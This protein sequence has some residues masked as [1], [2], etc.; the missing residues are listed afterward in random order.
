[1]IVNFD[2]GPDA[3]TTAIPKFK[4]GRWKDRLKAKKAVEH[5]ARKRAIETAE[6]NI[7][8]TIPITA[9]KTTA[10]TVKPKHGDEKS[11]QKPAPQ[12][13]KAAEFV[14]SLWTGNPEALSATTGDKEEEGEANEPSN[15]PLADGSA[16]FVTLGLS[17]ILANHLARKLA[18]RAPTAIQRS[19]IPELISTDSD[20]FIQAETGSGKTLTYLLPIV[21]RIMGLSA[22]PPSASQ[23]GKS[24]AKRTRHSGLYAIILAPTREL[25][26]QISTVLSTLIHCKNGPHWIVPGAVSGGE[27]KKSEKAR[28][29]K[30]INIL[31]ATPGR[32]LDHLQN[33][34]SLDV[35]RARWVV[36]DEGDRLMELGFEETIGNILGILEKKSKLPKNG[37]EAAGWESEAGLPRRRV[38]MLCSATMKANVQRLGDISLKEA[39]YIKAE[40]GYE[41]TGQGSKNEEEGFQAPAQLGQSYVIVPAK[42]RLVGLNAILRRAFIRQTAS[43]KIIVFFSCSDSVDFHFQVFSR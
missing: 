17:P 29:R 6:F 30:G 12:T 14:S 39:L 31:V 15:A 24:I 9:P 35:S 7:V 1:M 36:L 16:T 8:R 25:C 38:S 19:A 42:L 10:T 41:G 40:K 5:R 26:R 13:I 21:N 28:L 18:L 2:I 27:K 43:P 32:L 4:G 20:A 23:D 11:K 22:P 34:E 3:F 33:T 37:E